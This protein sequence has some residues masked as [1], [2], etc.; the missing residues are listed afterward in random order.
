MKR[1][2]ASKPG[3]RRVLK[4][5]FYTMYADN[6]DFKGHVS[7]L[8]LH[9]VK[10]PLVINMLGKDYCLVDKDYIWLELQPVDK[11]YC[12]TTMYNPNREIVQ[13]YFDITRQ[14]GIDENGIPF[15]DDLYLDVVVL[16]EGQVMLLDEDELKAALDSGEIDEEE[17]NMAYEEA[18]Q[19]MNYAAH[20]RNKLEALS[21]R[22][23]NYILPQGL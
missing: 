17:Y 20:S 23:L 14:N 9:E 5:S 13:W 21:N 11:H 15:F 10:E 1:K 16:P 6:S 4:K 22:Y 12:I 2:L 3:W 8:Q 19:L 18:R 7:A